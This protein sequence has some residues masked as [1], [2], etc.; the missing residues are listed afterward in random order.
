MTTRERCAKALT[1]A[2]LEAMYGKGGFWIKG[3]GFFTLKEVCKQ[4]GIVPE[5]RQIR[6]RIS[7]Y[8]DW[9]T[10]AYLNGVKP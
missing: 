2:G 6:E 5:P 8:G 3:S 9:A 1:D 10:I 4:Y 7:A